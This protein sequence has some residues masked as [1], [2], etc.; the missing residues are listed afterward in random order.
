MATEFAVDILFRNQTRGMDEIERKL[1]RLER[2]V[3]A[4]SG[5]PIDPVSPKAVPKAE[6]LK[7]SLDGLDRSTKKAGGGIGGLVAGLGKLAAAYASVDVAV[8]QVAQS[9]NRTLDL[10]AAQKRLQAATSSTLQYVQAQQIA[11]RAA[12][13]F[14][15]SQLQ[16]TDAISKVVGRLVPLGFNLR[17]IETIYGG[18]NTAKRLQ[19]LLLLKLRAR[20]RS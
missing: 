20:L 1:G 10:A 19:D 7:K 13:T 2:K 6:R 14:G 12:D 15:Q 16:S 9:V 5:K 3:K 17:E 18:F 4:L 11:A 8:R